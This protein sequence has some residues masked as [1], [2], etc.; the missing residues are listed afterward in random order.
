[1][2]WQKLDLKEILKIIGVMHQKLYKFYFFVL[3]ENKIGA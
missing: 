2:N 1:V 3:Y